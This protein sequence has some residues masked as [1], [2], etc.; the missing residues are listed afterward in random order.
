MEYYAVGTPVRR[1]TTTGELISPAA[2]AKSSHNNNN[3]NNNN[4]NEVTVSPQ[5]HP[6]AAAVVSSPT[7]NTNTNNLALLPNPLSVQAT[8]LRH[9]EY[10]LQSIQLQG[11]TNNGTGESALTF[12]EEGDVLHGVVDGP[13]MVLPPQVLLP[14]SL[15]PYLV[16]ESFQAL[17][18]L[19]NAAVYPLNS[20]QV[21]IELHGPNNKP[22]KSV[23]AKGVGSLPGKGNFALPVNAVLDM[24]EGE[25][26]LRADIVYHDGGTK[27][28]K[29]SWESSLAVTNGLVV[30]A[31]HYN[32]SN[33]RCVS[34]P[35]VDENKK[36]VRMRRLLNFSYVMKNVSKE[37]LVLTKTELRYKD[38]NKNKSND[39]NNNNR[40]MEVGLYPG[41]E[42]S[43]N[44]SID[45]DTTTVNNNNNNNEKI[46]DFVWTWNR[47]NGHSNHSKSNTLNQWQLPVSLRY[48]TAPPG[49]HGSY[50]VI[51][52]D[53]TSPSN[54]TNIK[55][56]PERVFH[57]GEP[58]TFHC[59]LL[60]HNHHNNN[61]TMEIGLKVRS[62][63]LAPDWC[64]AGQGCVSLGKLDDNNNKETIRYFTVEL[65]PWRTGWVAL[66]G[67]I[68]IVS[69]TNQALLLW[70]PLPP[71]E[72]NNNEMNNNNNNGIQLTVENT[73]NE[74][75]K[76]L[77]L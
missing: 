24:G 53:A 14:S 67:G 27:E 49:H 5:E 31:S 15:Q 11:N 16:G 8:I 9:P 34:I 77:V 46:G 61:N 60:F 38:E 76:L 56:F 63:K 55:S 33:S 43:G 42:Y 59:A 2:A 41:D 47:L 13:A 66:R 28:K 54:S 72:N 52:L 29:L 58:I 50:E 35:V 51:V 17:L 7:A 44:Y 69:Y 20:L 30:T 3:N 1:A 57:S 45:V 68:E 25:Y 10:N 32:N 70:S 21:Q 22:H 6:L 36:L 4:N 18:V 48:R 62:E 23:Y 73:S 74:L 12:T 64:Y 65:L 19:Q 75:C 39:N 26:K 37:Y 40:A 71:K